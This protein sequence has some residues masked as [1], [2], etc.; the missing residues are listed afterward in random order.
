MTRSPAGIGACV[1]D[2]YGTMFDVHSAVAACRAEIGAHADRLSESWRT[3]QLQYTWLRSLMGAYADFWTVTGEALD[4]SMRA[5]GIDNRALR[6]K[7]MQ[8]YLKLTAYDDV[9]PTL[10]KL[11][12][13]GLRTA[14][15]SNGNHRMLQA[16]VASA[17]IGASLDAVLSVDDVGIYKP[18]KRVYQ[19]AVDRLGLPAER[20]C[21]LSSNAWDAHAAAHFGFHVF[22]CNRTQQPREGLPGELAGEIKSLAELPALLQGVAS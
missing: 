21:F 1:F 17:G 3:R 7:L 2:A 6:E 11:R 4:V 12:T 10:D 16:A 20:I 8:L 13:S 19:L 5:L 15:L 14:I 9:A 22:W 18:D